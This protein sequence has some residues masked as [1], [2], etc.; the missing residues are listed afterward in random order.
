M[1]N[2]IGEWLLGMK[3]TGKREFY[4]VVDGKKE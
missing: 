4:L 3:R 2:E 1:G